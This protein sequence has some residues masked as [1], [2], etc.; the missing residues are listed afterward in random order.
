MNESEKR[1][2]ELEPLRQS[3]PIRSH[4]VVAA[5]RR[6]A[7][8]LLL[9]GVA[10]TAV[11][12]G[13]SASTGTSGGAFTNIAVGIIAGAFFLARVMTVLAFILIS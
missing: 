4:G 13:N 12:Y 2:S 3:R 5:L 1:S 11:W 6:V 9:A 10:E 8:I 7:L